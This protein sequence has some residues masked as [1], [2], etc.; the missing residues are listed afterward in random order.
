M[1]NSL[2]RGVGLP[3]IELID[4]PVQVEE[5][6]GSFSTVLPFADDRVTF[7]VDNNLGELIYSYANEQRRPVNGKS[8]ATAMNVLISKFADNDGNEFTE[9]EFN[10]FP[11]L[12]AVSRMSILIT[13]ATS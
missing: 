12:N 10:A 6:D 2:F 4:Y 8:Y 13:D 9:G 7:V 3:V 5:K 11:V 1:V